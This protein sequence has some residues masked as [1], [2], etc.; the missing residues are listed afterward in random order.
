MAKGRPVWACVTTMPRSNSPET[1]RMKAS[2]SR[3]AVSMPACTLNT[4]ALNGSVVWRGT[5]STSLRGPG[6]GAKVT[7][8]SSSWRTPKFSIAEA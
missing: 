7:R 2:R 5:P 3:C 6:G 8:V 4:T 1:M